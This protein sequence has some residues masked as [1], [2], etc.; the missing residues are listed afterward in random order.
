ME[1]VRARVSSSLPERVRQWSLYA[2]VRPQCGFAASA[3][4]C[5]KW[6]GPSPPWPDWSCRQQSCLQRP[7]R[8]PATPWY[9]AGTCDG[10]LESRWAGRSSALRESGSSSADRDGQVLPARGPE[11]SARSAPRPGLP[12]TSA[13]SWRQAR[14][15]APRDRSSSSKIPCAVVAA[16]SAGE[17]ERGPTAT[18]DA[19]SRA[20]VAVKR[21][22][23]ER[24]RAPIRRRRSGAWSSPLSPRPSTS[25]EKP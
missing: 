9:V 19:T 7:C 21:G 1:A 25:D 6:G 8:R 13:R 5:P 3:F 2:S 16:L 12:Q 15:Q 14:Q 23:R 11:R 20:G 22:S 17:A 4:L 10:A 18:R 24:L